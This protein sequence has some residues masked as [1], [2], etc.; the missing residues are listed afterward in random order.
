MSAVVFTGTCCS[1]W[2]N[3]CYVS[4]GES[5]SIPK[6][7]RFNMTL[8]TKRVR[9]IEGGVI[10]YDLGKESITIRAESLASRAFV[11]EIRK[12]RCNARGFVT[13]EPETKSSSAAQY[14]AILAVPGM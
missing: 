4:G 10:V 2:D 13:I 12:G 7:T 3:P 5:K 8:E 1:A 11:K 14:K 9:S 6:T